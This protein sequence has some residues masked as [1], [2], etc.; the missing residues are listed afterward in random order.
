MAIERVDGCI[1]GPYDLSG[2]LG[3]PG[4]WEHTSVTQA[5]DKVKSILEE[6]HKPGGYHVVHSNHQELKQ[7]IN[8][9]YKFIAYGDDMVFFAET[10]A[11]ETDFISELK[12]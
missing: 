3:V 9:G 11:A 12:K 6:N 10:I 4:Q 5:L 2:S 1:I 7:R 8:E